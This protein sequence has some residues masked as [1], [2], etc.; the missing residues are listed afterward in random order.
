MKQH[1][2]AVTLGAKETDVAP[3]ENLKIRPLDSGEGPYPPKNRAGKPGMGSVMVAA[4]SR[5]SS[6]ST[7][8]WPIADRTRCAARLY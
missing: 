4:S 1:T 5:G 3:L 7:P 6:R 2:S 8:G